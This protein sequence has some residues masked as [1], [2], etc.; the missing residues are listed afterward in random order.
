MSGEL[1]APGGRRIEILD[2]WRGIAIIY[3]LFYHILCDFDMLGFEWAH[4]IFRSQDTVVL[5]DTGSF[6]VLAGLCCSL[7]RNN[8][9]RGAKLLCVSVLLTAGTYIAEPRACI[10]FGVLHLMSVGM[11][12]WAAGEKWLRKLPAVP[13]ALLCAV[14]FAFT[15]NVKNG[16][17]GIGSLSFPVPDDLMYNSRLACF[18][19]IDKSYAALDYVPILPNIFLFLCGAF[20]G[21]WLLKKELPGFCYK[22]VPFIGFLGRHSLMIYLIHQPICYGIIY[23]VAHA[24]GRI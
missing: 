1:A 17:F 12:V 19:F 6:I 7:S 4:A 22:R 23:L 3:M 14:L 5:F 15:Y 9:L 10:T 11:L 18:G 13:F 20:L 16:W 24:T 21:K 8:A 2:T